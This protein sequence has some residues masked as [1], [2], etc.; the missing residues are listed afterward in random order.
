MSTLDDTR[1]DS[2]QLFPARREL[3]LVAQTR[4]RLGDAVTAVHD[5]LGKDADRSPWRVEPLFADSPDEGTV[6]RGSGDYE[7]GSSDYV[8]AAIELSHVLDRSDVFR[9]VQADLPA[10]A[11]DRA[12]VDPNQRNGARRESDEA[13]ASL[14][15]N[16][17]LINLETA[18]Q[19][20]PRWRH[21]GAGV[22]IGLPDTGYTDH[23]AVGVALYDLSNDRDFIDDDDDSLD[24]LRRR[25]FPW[26]RF[27]SPG[28][29]T[30][31]ASIIASHGDPRITGRRRRLKLSEIVGVAPAAEVLPLRATNSTVQ[32]FA[33]DLARAINHARLSH[34]HVVSIGMGTTGFFG[35]DIATRKAVEDG[36]IVLAAAGDNPD[37]LSAPA[38]F[39]SCIGVAAVSP[40]LEPWAWSSAGDVVDIAAP[41]RGVLAATYDLEGELAQPMVAPLSSTSFAACHVA[42]VAALWLARHSRRHLLKQ[43]GRSGIQS[44][45]VH[46][47]RETASTP[48]GWDSRYG[49]GVVNAA[50]VVEH[51]LPSLEMVSPVRAH[52]AKSEEP[53]QRLAGLIPGTDPVTVRERLGDLLGAGGAQLDRLA[54]KH[55]AELAYLVI[56][57][58]QLRQRLL[59]LTAADFQRRDTGEPIEFGCP[60]SDP[61]RSRLYDV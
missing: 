23:P 8:S 24:P 2:T 1:R 4:S 61:L 7:I 45:F 54:A 27:S 9:T 47:L 18:W 16:H 42:G 33:S 14:R 37:I 55:E 59:P 36:L 44:A 32:F 3:R 6:I 11:F 57:N 19:S 53:T 49:A 52:G 51:P 40:N 43:Y 17:E 60:L 29:G 21:H 20:G 35:L 38:C 48:D 30:A 34:C 46:I 41:G 39:D 12:M 58:Q 56:E 15:W 28:H 25:R 13:P 5:L 50:A 10:I 31:S 22:R 26:Q